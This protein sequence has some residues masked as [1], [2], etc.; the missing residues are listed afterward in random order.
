[1]YGIN[2]GILEIKQIEYLLNTKMPD[3]I[4]VDKGIM[5][6]GVGDI[7]E[8]HVRQIIIDN[9]PDA[10]YP[11]S[12]RSIED[13]EMQTDNKILKLDIKT[14]NLDASFSRPNLI[15]IKRLNDYYKDPNNS[16]AYIFVSYKFDK[17]SIEIFDI[18]VANI[19]HIKWDSLAIGNLGKG[20]LQ[21]N[22]MHKIEF[23][24][25]QKRNEWVDTFRKNGILYYNK[26]TEK[27][28]KWKKSF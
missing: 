7:V 24:F 3:Y 9:Y 19:E 27:I 28:Q 26:L 13:V 23:D 25:D 10:Y 5:Q 20:Q 4:R 14:H 1:M 21:V 16:L 18:S 11:S 2:T 6:R 15:S 12:A 17:D 8:A 22:N